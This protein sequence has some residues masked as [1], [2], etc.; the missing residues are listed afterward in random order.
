LRL[1]YLING[2]AGRIEWLD[3]SLRFFYA[4]ITP[5]LATALVALIFL[6]P[7]GADGSTPFSRRRLFGSLAVSAALCILVVIA[8]NAFQGQALGRA[9]MSPRPFMTHWANVLVVEPNGNSFPC[10]EVMFAAATA[11]LIWAI[12]PGGGILAWLL[13]CGLGFARIYCGSNYL[14]DSVAGAALGGALSTLALACC[15]VP[16]RVPIL[17]AQTWRWR[18]RHQGVFG[19]ATL[20]VLFAGGF[21]WLWT[22]PPHEAKLRAWLGG[23]VLGPSASAAPVGATPVSAASNAPAVSL[24]ENIH[25][26]E[27][28]PASGAASAPG[29]M[30]LDSRAAR[31]D[32]HLPEAEKYLQQVLSTLRPP[33]PIMGINVAQVVAGTTGY[34]CAA[35]RFEVPHPDTIPRSGAGARPPVNERA[36][37][38]QTAAALIRLAF[39]ADAQLQHVDVVGLQHNPAPTLAP[40]EFYPAAKWRPVFT[41]SLERRDLIITRPDKPRWVNDPRLEGG[42]WLRA[43]SLLY[44]DAEVLPAAVARPVVQSPVV[45]PPV[46]QPPVVQSPALKPVAPQRTTPKPIPA[47]TPTPQLPT[48]QLP[49]LVGATGEISSFQSAAPVLSLPLIPG[50]QAPG[51][52]PAS[53]AQPAPRTEAETAPSRRRRTRRFRRHRRYRRYR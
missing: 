42:L 23:G 44:I 50:A 48:P 14:A 2:W 33:Y 46:V 37:V 17:H 49:T 6:W 12:S 9:P 13:V 20:L 7:Q 25:E 8:I 3:D 24:H 4:G 22:S 18:L 34:R 15:R 29:E 32:G 47:S 19:A 27:G 45:Q 43:R 28:A 26:G 40:S 16:L 30:L 51:E 52:Q 5:L 10:Y 41:A 21:Y 36:R 31:L 1:F 39:Q 53:A 38:A 35:I 11:T